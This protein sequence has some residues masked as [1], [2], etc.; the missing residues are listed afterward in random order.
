MYVIVAVDTACSSNLQN[1]HGITCYCMLAAVAVSVGM[2]T[3]VQAYI[4]LS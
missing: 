1:Q 3:S 2:S 4:A